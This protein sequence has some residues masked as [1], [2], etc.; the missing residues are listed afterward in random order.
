MLPSYNKP[1]FISHWSPSTS[2]A[3]VLKMWSVDFWESLLRF[4]RVCEVKTIF[5][6]ILALL[7][8]IFI[9]LDICTNGT[10]ATVDKTASA[11]P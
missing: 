4:H 7:F 5:I 10:L 6:I 2:Y 11:F 3:V 1:L 9:V 8:T